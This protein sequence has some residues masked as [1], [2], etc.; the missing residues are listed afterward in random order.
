MPATI[1]C[2]FSVN[3]LAVALPF[4]GIAALPSPAASETVRV[5]T[6]NLA[7]YDQAAGRVL[8]RLESGDDPQARC[9]AEIIQRVRPDILV[10]NEIDYDADGRVLAAFCD[11][12]L[13]VGQ[14]AS[15]APA[16]PAEPI[17]YPHRLAFASNTGEHSGLD[18]DRNGR[19][20][21]TPGARDYAGDC[22]GYGVYPGQY[23]FAVLSK[24]PLDEGAV[25]QFRKFAWRDMPG[26]L[27]PN[28][29]ATPAPQDWYNA[30]ALPQVRLSSKN[31]CD[32][33]VTVAGRRL[34]LLL[35]H[36]TPPVFDGPED[37][38]GRRN[39]DELRFWRDYIAAKPP[40]Y[41]RD[42]AGRAGALAT[43]EPFIILGDLNG[44][45]HDGD[46]AEGIKQL[47]GAP[48]VLQYAA[49]TSAGAVEAARLQGGANAR[50]VGDHAQDTEDAAD[51][52][53]PGNLRLDYVLPSRDLKVVASG[54]FWP[55]TDD[56]LYPLVR[57]AEHP[58]S[59]DH[60]L[61]WIDL[62]L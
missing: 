15:Q 52:P 61:T 31:H 60:R 55:T 9:L 39:H 22:W 5:A 58:A 35:S 18:L 45:A 25:R 43:G 49:P 59:S 10:L 8:A 47:L 38:N 27:I 34:H 1:R 40:A 44:D 13:A 36:P 37:R 32:V 29:P 62:E 21:A 6:F 30:E 53:G 11:K 28:D 4:A 16:G 26:A 14:H 24:F 42:D 33:P 7:L 48:E 51:V 12:Y 23:A 41:F 57:G 54:V 56:P 50:H 17:A 2:R 20:D 19:V 3:F 46:G